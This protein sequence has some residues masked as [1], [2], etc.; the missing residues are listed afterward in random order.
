MSNV[1]TYFS[2]K[3]FTYLNTSRKSTP[4]NVAA[5]QVDHSVTS[6]PKSLRNLTVLESWVLAATFLVGGIAVVVSV[7]L[8]QLTKHWQLDGECQSVHV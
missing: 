2:L 7:C 1:Y 8:C 5:E 4:L 6:S 3:L